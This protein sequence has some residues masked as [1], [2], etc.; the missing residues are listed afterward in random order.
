MP[1]INM[2]ASRRADKVRRENNLRRTFYAIVGEVGVVLLCLSFLSVRLGAIAAEDAELNGKIQSLQPT[3]SQIQM[4]QN[5][6]ARLMPKVQTL[7]GAKTDTLFW[8]NSIYA[9]TNSLPAKT[10]LTSL[11]TSAGPGAGTAPGAMTGTDPTLNITGIATS[12][13]D[14]GQTMLRMDQAPGMDHV[15][16]AFDQEQKTGQADSVAFQMTVHL[17]PEPGVSPPGG[18]SAAKS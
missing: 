7:D 4:L 3:V 12:H 11:G 15:D 14:V 6:T 2:I 18:P 5:E 8:Y 9:V 16:L 13:A 17:K 10:W 1:S